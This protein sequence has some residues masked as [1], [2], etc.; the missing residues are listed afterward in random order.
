MQ[1]STARINSNKLNIS[2]LNYTTGVDTDKYINM[3]PSHI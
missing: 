3:N 1:E 2:L